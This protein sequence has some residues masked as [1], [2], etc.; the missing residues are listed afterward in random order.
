MMGN[1]HVRSLEI[2]VEISEKSR[3][4]GLQTWTRLM[5]GT[6]AFVH[7]EYP[8]TEA[9]ATRTPETEHAA[10]T[11][12]LRIRKTLTRPL[13]VTIRLQSKRTRSRAWS[14]R[15]MRRA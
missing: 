12:Q 15:R 9:P 1:D 7:T 4:L 6:A 3:I 5:E 2:V 14:R 11:R 8:R 13:R 10:T